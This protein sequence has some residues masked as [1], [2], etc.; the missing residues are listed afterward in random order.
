[1]FILFKKI[2]IFNVIRLILIT[3]ILH[4]LQSL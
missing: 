2:N 4:L 3:L 1:M